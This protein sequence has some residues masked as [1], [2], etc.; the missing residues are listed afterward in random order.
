[1]AKVE[2]FVKGDLDELREYVISGLSRLYVT[3]GVE[4]EFLGESNG[5]RYWLMAGEKYSAIG[6]NRMS[7]NVTVIEEDDNNHVMATSTGAS[8]GV[9]IKINTWSESELLKDFAN[10]LENWERKIGSR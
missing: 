2:R 8:Q 6:G 1:M 5:H 9:F 3:F 4:D 10:I 7:I